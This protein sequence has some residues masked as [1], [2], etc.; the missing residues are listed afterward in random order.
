MM[1]NPSF[2]IFKRKADL[3]ISGYT[4]KSD[5]YETLA[6]GTFSSAPVRERDSR[7]L[8]RKDRIWELF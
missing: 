8:L 6:C 4:Q 7:H 3:D 1:Q 2:P 5:F